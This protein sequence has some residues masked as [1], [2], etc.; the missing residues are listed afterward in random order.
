MSSRETNLMCL[1]RFL[2]YG[3]DE[4]QNDILTEL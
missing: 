4:D 3:E 2:E 1:S